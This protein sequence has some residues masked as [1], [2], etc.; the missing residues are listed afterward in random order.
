MFTVQSYVGQTNAICVLWHSQFIIDLSDGF[1]RHNYSNFIS[2]RTSALEESF[3][4][5]VYNFTQKINDMDAKQLEYD[6]L[7]LKLTV[8]IESSHC[9][10][11]LLELLAEF[12]V[13][14][15]QCFCRHLWP[16]SR[17]YPSWR[18]HFCW[19]AYI[20]YGVRIAINF[21]FSTVCRQLM[22][23][24]TILTVY[25]LM[26]NQIFYWSNRIK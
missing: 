10:V 3:E 7:I 4:K 6:E 23:R 2:I 17:I 5:D 1:N 8:A 25:C 20:R 14:N 22:T 12:N 11:S 26:N 15:V 19:P 21:C 16:F 24:N 13:Q 9:E 18:M